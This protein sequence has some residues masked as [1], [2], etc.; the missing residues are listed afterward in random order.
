MNCIYSYII[1]PTRTHTLNIKLHHIKQIYEVIILN[2]QETFVKTK[3]ILIGTSF[4]QPKL[5]II[6][7][8]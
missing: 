1:Y 6:S 2:I 3:A 8:I 5:N 4:R 7:K